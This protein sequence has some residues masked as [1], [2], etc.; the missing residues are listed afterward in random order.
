MKVYMSIGRIENLSLI[1]LL[2]VDISLG[3]L[4]NGHSSVSVAWFT[5]DPCLS[6]SELRFSEDNFSV[7]A[8]EGYEHRIALG[9]V[10]FS[11]GVHY[12]EFTIDRYSTDTDPSFGIA[13]IDVAKDQMLGMIT[14][15]YLYMIV[16]LCCCMMELWLVITV[17]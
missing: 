15:T 7:S 11:R 13:R 17:R 12:W 4:K 8:C 3:M 2:L 9:S 5:F 16:V 6:G 14:V 10:G 1:I